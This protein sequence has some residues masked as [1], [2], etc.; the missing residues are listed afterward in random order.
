MAETSETHWRSAGEVLRAVARP[1]AQITR[2]V[3]TR[4]AL[5]AQRGQ[6]PRAVFLPSAGRD[7][8]ALLRIYNM[9]DRLCDHGWRTLVLPRALTL[10]QRHRLLA[11]AAPDIVVMQGVRHA[12]NRPALYP[13]QQIVLDMDDADFHLPHLAAPLQR[14]MGGVQ[15]VVAGSDYVAAWC[16]GAGAPTVYTVLTGMPVS[17]GSRPSQQMRPPVVAWAQ[18]RP[19]TYTH[20]ADLVRAVMTG[21]VARIPGVRLRLYDRRP[22]DD[23]GFLASFEAAGIPTEWRAGAGAVMR[24]R[25]VFAWEIGGQ[26]AGVS[27]PPRSGHRQ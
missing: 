5:M 14:A 13:G 2:M 24:R 9:A 18:T 15:A 26:G 23:P 10:A 22:D 17:P 25:A 21:L 4:M 27:R 8:A 3:P 11:A 19:M 20:E 12:L 6:G 16:R 1:V 7:G